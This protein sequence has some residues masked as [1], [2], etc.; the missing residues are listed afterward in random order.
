MTTAAVGE[1][2][3]HVPVSV[4]AG[5]S[6]PESMVVPASEA[7]AS[8]RR[9]SRP[10][11]L[12]VAEPPFAVAARAGHRAGAAVAEKLLVSARRPGTRP[13]RN[14]PLR[15]PLGQK[16]VVESTVVMVAPAAFDDR[17]SIST[18]APGLTALL[19]LQAASKRRARR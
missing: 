15:V 16:P 10:G 11:R 13:D 7:A 1:G 18:G 8:A 14:R 12:R 17:S 4:V 3:F 2:Q 5:P 9:T 6:A 19:G